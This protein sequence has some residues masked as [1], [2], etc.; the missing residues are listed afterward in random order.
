MSLARLKQVLRDQFLIMQLD[1]D[2][3]IAAIPR[4]LPTDAR[5]RDAGKTAIRRVLGATGDLPEDGKRRLE[6]VEALFSTPSQGRGT[7]EKQST[8]A[9][10]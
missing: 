5:L 3:A 10:D 4:L 2:R 8:L 1:E 9:A 7:A 6:R